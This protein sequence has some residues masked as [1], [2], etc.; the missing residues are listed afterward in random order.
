MG[1]QKRKNS[2]PK[3]E[4]IEVV[5]TFKCSKGHEVPIQFTYT[6]SRGSMRE[7]R[8]AVYSP[9]CSQCGWTKKMSGHESISIRQAE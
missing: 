3:E 5:V 8:D 7:L 6:K 9:L 1:I 2:Q 4:W